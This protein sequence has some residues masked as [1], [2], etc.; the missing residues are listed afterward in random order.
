MHLGLL[1][2]CLF[3]YFNLALRPPLHRRAPQMP[4]FI[5][6]QLFNR[7]SLLDVAIAARYSQRY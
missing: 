6:K 1:T 4:H 2:D 3:R 7:V 5:D